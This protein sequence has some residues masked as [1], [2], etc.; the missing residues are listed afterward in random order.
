HASNG[1]SYRI[2][3]KREHGGLV[4]NHLHTAMQEGDCLELGPPCGEFVLD[5]GV[6]PLVLV[7]AGV[8]LT[9]AMAMLNAAAG[10]RDIHFVHA[11]KNEAQH[12]FKA[13]TEELARKHSNIQVAYVYE[14]RDGLLDRQTL[15]KHLPNNAQ[16]Y[17]LGPPGFM[18]HVKSM[19]DELGV[20]STRQ[21]VEFFGPAQTLQ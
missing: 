2:S 20:P 5:Q 18:Q 10:L 8:G 6:D 16:V 15:A 13:S 3:V 11:C 9:P 14:D 1:Q 17:Y 7:T 4:S 19:L 12:S 21:H